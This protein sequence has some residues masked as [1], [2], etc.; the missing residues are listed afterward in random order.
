[1]VNPDPAFRRL[2]FF[3]LAGSRGG[4]NRLRIIQYLKD[5]PSNANL[6]STELK[7]DYKTVRHHLKVLEQ[8]SLIVESQK[9]AYGSSYFVS[10]YL[11]TQYAMVEEIWAKVNKSQKSKEGDHA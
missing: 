1:M 11:Q 7:L 9:G 5:N 8:N 4:F 3:L 2:V 6:I 10:D